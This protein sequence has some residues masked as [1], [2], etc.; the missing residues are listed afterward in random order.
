MPSALFGVNIIQYAGETSKQAE[1]RYFEHQLVQEF[2]KT[3]KY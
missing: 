1:E 3:R 2:R